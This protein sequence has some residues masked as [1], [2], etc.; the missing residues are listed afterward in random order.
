MRQSLGLGNL[1]SNPLVSRRL[2]L[3]T[4]AI[5]GP[6]LAAPTATP[7]AVA[8]PALLMALALTV[9]VLAVALQLVDERESS[10][11]FGI[12]EAARE[13]RS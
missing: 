12:T 10:V 5:C 7:I 2:P 11:T 13:R 6:G 1:P 8:T 3:V 4:G 9:R